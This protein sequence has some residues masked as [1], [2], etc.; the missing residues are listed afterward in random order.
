MLGFH[1]EGGVRLDEAMEGGW[2]GGFI[3][4]EVDLRGAVVA[5]VVGGGDGDEDDVG[6]VRCGGPVDGEEDPLV[7]VVGGRGEGARGGRRGQPAD[8]GGVDGVGEGAGAAGVDV[9]V[10][11][12][13]AVWIHWGKDQRVIGQSDVVIRIA[14]DGA[15]AS[16][17]GDTHVAGKGR[18]HGL[19]VG[20]GGK[21]VAFGLLPD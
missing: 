12:C 19:N 3:N 14:G 5:V 13:R 20:D 15:V 11:G 17:D 1:A 2:H 18:F 9:Y 21:S 16:F 10:T 8:A 7:G 6:A 4:G